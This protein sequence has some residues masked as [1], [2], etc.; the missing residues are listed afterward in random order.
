MT[1]VSIRA[2]IQYTLIRAGDPPDGEELPYVTNQLFLD[3]SE[4]VSK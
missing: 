3:F 4:D 1:I 2:L